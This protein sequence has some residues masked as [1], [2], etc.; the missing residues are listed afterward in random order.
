MILTFRRVVSPVWR[1]TIMFSRHTGRKPA[2]FSLLLPGVIAAIIVLIA[3]TVT[4]RSA[5]AATTTT[6]TPAATSHVDVMVLNTEINPASLRYLTDSIATAE[7]DGS[8]ALVIEIDT[9]GGDLDSMKAMTQAELSS[10]VPIISYVSPAGGRA[11]SAGAFVTLAAPIAAMAPTTRIGAS[12]PIDS[13]GADIGSTLK[14]KIENDLVQ[15][16]KGIQGRYH[17]DFNDA[18]LMVTQAK[19]YD[20][21]TAINDGIVDL[22]AA[23]LNNLLNQVN[24]RTVALE[25]KSVTL[26]TAGVSTQMLN[27]SIVDTLYGWI[28]DPNIVFLLFIVAM[29][30][31]YLEISHPGAILPGTAGGIALLL[32]LLGA[33]SLSPNWAGLGLMVLAFV[34]LVLD[35][36]VPTH[37]IL[38]IGAVFSLVFGALLFFN[39][40]GPYNGPQVNPYVVYTMAGVIAL[41]SFALI[42][43]IMRVQRQPITTGVE[44]MIGAKATA[45][46]PL[47]PE[48]RVNYGGEDWAAVLEGASSIDAGVQVQV[49]G[50]D[51][52]RLH[53]RPVRSQAELDA[54]AIPKIE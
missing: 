5:T 49:V 11:A 54:P 17:R 33:G 3:F 22:G 26:Q 24:G 12:S 9:P 1:N 30:G 45:M 10:T 25:S 32:F 42:T 6:T 16:L 8:Q 23:N 50:V 27:P 52:L 46:T 18:Q 38:T 35:L 36:R 41:I 44:G 40:G 53:V 14:L 19:S 15:S 34:L 37:G 39:S 2:S 47:I 31:I 21:A 13:T 51:G 4:A 7:S 48:G 28:I 43:V 20:D 29:I